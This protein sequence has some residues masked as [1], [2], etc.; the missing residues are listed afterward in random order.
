MGLATALYGVMD[1]MPDTLAARM[2]RMADGT[3]P[4]YL[5]FDHDPTEG[6]KGFLK[7]AHVHTLEPGE[8]RWEHR[9]G[10]PYTQMW[11]AGYGGGGNTGQANSCYSRY[12]QTGIEGYKTL[13]MKS[14]EAY[15]AVDPPDSK[16]L[17]PGN[18]SSLFS[19]MRKAYELTGEERFLIKAKFYMDRSVEGIMDDSS[20][21]PKASNKSDHY[22]AITG[23]PGLM[24]NLLVLWMDMNGVS[25]A[26]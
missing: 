11:S 23:G 18:Y 6:G 14:A 13:F 2:K 20:P 19:M 9:G 3:D 1:Q 10:N 7:S 5:S 4:I 17:Y 16:V 22:E 12:R 24:N 15:Y 25:D 26:Y 21:L 8:Y